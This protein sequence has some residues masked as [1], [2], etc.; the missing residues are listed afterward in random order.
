M[1]ALSPILNK[2]FQGLRVEDFSRLAQLFIK[3]GS[4]P[5][6][7]QLSDLE[8]E[9]IVG[10]LQLLSQSSLVIREPERE[11]QANL[12]ELFDKGLDDPTKISYWRY[13]LWRDYHSASIGLAAVKINLPLSLLVRSVLSLGEMAGYES[14]N[15]TTPLELINEFQEM[16][17]DLIDMN[18]DEIVF[19]ERSLFNVQACWRGHLLAQGNKAAALKDTEKKKLDQK[20]FVSALGVLDPKKVAQIL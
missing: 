10:L 14:V 19:Y 13:K 15:T 12:I 2:N 20:I 4:L 1:Q 16:A 11:L 8:W 9:R 3:A 7:D 18:A 17:S 5:A 6:I